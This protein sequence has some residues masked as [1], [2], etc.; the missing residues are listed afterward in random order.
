M[1]HRDAQVKAGQRRRK[2]G[3]GIAVHQHKIRLFSLQHR[4]Q[5]LQDAGGDIKQRLARLHDGNIVFRLHMERL[6]HLIQHLPVLA[7]HAA[8]GLDAAAP[9][10][11]LHQRAH[12][13]RFGSGPEH[14]HDLFHNL[15]TPSSVQMLRVSSTT[16]PFSLSI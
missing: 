3:G 2:G 11:L 9:A 12:L 13:D 7:G 4:L 14:Q 10:Q 5:V 8:D 6:Q 16:L 15:Y 1:A